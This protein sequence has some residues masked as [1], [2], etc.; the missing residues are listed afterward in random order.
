M[1][2]KIKVYE[3]CRMMHVIFSSFKFYLVWKI[4]RLRAPGRHLFFPRIFELLKS[5]HSIKRHDK[6]TKMHK[7]PANFINFNYSNNFDLVPLP[8]PSR[9]RSVTVPLPFLVLIK[10]RYLTV[11]SPLP[12]RYGPLLTVTDVTDRY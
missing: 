2:A 7:Y 4:F 8:L 1:K 10:H 3:I 5:V 12:Y 9:Y 6:K 11:T